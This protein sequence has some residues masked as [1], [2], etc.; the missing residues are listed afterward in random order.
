M[1]LSEVSLSHQRIIE[2][3]LASV[4]LSLSLPWGTQPFLTGLLWLRAARMAQPAPAVICVGQLSAPTAI[5]PP[6]VDPHSQSCWHDADAANCQSTY[7]LS[8][9]NENI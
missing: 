7:K 5:R 1:Y 4:R 6:G 8:D 2:H 3:P 9:Q